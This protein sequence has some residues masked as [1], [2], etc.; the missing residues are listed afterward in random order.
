M[1]NVRKTYKQHARQGVR[2]ISLRL[3]REFGLEI[4]L[5]ATGEQMIFKA[6]RIPRIQ[7]HLT[8]STVMSLAPATVISCL[9]DQDSIPAG[10]SH[11][12]GPEECLGHDRHPINRGNKG[13]KEKMGGILSG[14]N[15]H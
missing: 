8:I 9:G 2:G 4:M 10:F 12:K 11:S 1:C 5:G 3:R 14:D 6:M 13:I 15:T 7:L